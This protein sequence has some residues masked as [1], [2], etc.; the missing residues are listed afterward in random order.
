VNASAYQTSVLHYCTQVIKQLLT[1]QCKSQKLL[2]IG[3]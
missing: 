3:H 1:A 2:L